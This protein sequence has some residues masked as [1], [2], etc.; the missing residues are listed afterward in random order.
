METSFPLLLKSNWNLYVIKN[1]CWEFLG[2]PLVSAQ[3]T[4]V[5]LGSV[6]GRGTEI[7]QVVWRSK[8]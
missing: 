4:S 3:L 5:A 8:K 7:L 2:E 1:K 6:P